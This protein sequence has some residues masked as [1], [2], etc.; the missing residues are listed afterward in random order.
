MVKSKAVLTFGLEE[1]ELKA[2][3]GVLHQPGFGISM[4]QS[5]SQLI[6]GAYFAAII[7][8]DAISQ[9]E[10]GALGAFFSKVDGA[11]TT[12][13]FLTDKEDA[14]TKTTNAQIFYSLEALL[15]KIDGILKKAYD[16]ARRQE[17]LAK[18]MAVSFFILQAIKDNP[19]VSTVHLAERLKRSEAAVKRYIEELCMA[20]KN[21]VY[22]YSLEGWRIQEATN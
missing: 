17:N 22:D 12:K 20:G 6:N 2:I 4:A 10:S 3:V 18:S 15:D 1:Q 11:S 21:I 13:I 14:L 16:R 9:S 7:R 5:N 19:G 8:R